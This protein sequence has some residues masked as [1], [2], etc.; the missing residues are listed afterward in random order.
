MDKKRQEDYQQMIIERLKELSRNT[1][2]DIPAEPN[3][4]K[5]YRDALYDAC[6]LIESLPP[7]A[8]P[9]KRTETHTCVL[10][11]RQMA[12]GA[13]LGDK[14]QITDVIRAIGNERDFEV[15]NYTCD[16]HAE[17]LKALPPVQLEQ[18]KHGEWLWD[19]DT[20]DW[21]RLHYCSECKKYALKDT[22]GKEV[23]SDFC[24]LCGADMRGEIE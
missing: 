16:R 19:R 24:P 11:D 5:Y 17:I 2:F 18:S 21:E 6:Q 13:M 8:Q 3:A 15:L 10:I 14:V 4:T 7:I 23:L 20:L 22:D 9:E 12:I 1:V